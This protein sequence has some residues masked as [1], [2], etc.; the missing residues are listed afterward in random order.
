MKREEEE[1]QHVKISH[2]FFSIA[3][4]KKKRKKKRIK[5]VCINVF[6]ITSKGILNIH[7]D[8]YYGTIIKYRTLLDSF[9]YF[10]ILGMKIRWC[11]ELCMFSFFFLFLLT[12]KHFE[13][14]IFSPLASVYNIT[15]ETC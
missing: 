6:V 14:F 15:H 12:D 9:I 8:R 4:K 1:K 13:Y 10:Y 3:V 7:F 2:D 11:L 5:V